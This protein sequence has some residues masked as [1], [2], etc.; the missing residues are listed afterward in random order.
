MALFNHYIK[1]LREKGVLKQILAKYESAPQVCPDDSGKP[2][3]LESCF[4]AFLALFG[5]KLAVIIQE[6]RTENTLFKESSLEESFG[7]L[8]TYQQLDSSKGSLKAQ[9]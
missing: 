7:Y 5:G 1:E 6:N 2:L 3:G 8:S 4:T 9:I